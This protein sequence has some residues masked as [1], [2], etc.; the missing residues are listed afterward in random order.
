M[1]VTLFS[2]FTVFCPLYDIKMFSLFLL[3]NVERSFLQAQ[4]PVDDKY[5]T[6]VEM[7]WI[8]NTGIYI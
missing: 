4:S 7:K 2:D 8:R 3:E 5:D 6:L 1:E